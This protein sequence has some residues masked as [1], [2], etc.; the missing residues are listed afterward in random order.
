MRQHVETL[1]AEIIRYYHEMLRFDEE[2][3]AMRIST[4]F[5]KP[6]SLRFADIAER[7]SARSRETS[8]LAA[9]LSQQ[10]QQETQALLQQTHSVLPEVRKELAGECTTHCREVQC[11]N[12]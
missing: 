4:S 8:E 11:L 6:F 9:V 7:V 10:Q 1:Y 5:I 12:I 3:R 2:G